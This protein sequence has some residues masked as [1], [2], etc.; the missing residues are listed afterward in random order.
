MAQ[1]TIL[2]VS[3]DELEKTVGNFGSNLS[4]VESLTQQMI[5]TGA[6]R[7]PALM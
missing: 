5:W 6:T 2:K 7:N 1:Q 4:K 3:T